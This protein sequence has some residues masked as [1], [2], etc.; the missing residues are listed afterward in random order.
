MRALMR[1]APFHYFWQMVSRSL[2]PPPPPPPPLPHL[3]GYFT[4]FLHPS[5]LPLHIA[6]VSD[7]LYVSL[8]RFVLTFAYFSKQSA[9]NAPL[10][11][12]QF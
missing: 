11:P 5:S 12:I 8:M 10:P 3:F 2:P 6:A 4:F 1:F 9:M 7:W